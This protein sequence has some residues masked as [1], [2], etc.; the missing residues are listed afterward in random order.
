MIAVNRSRLQ[1]RQPR[2]FILT[3]V[4]ETS[5]RSEAGSYFAV[6]KH[7]GRQIRRSLKTTDRGIAR[8]KLAEF[9]QQLRGSVPAAG[10]AGA[11]LTFDQLAKRWL[12]PVAVHLKS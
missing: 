3:R 2:R 5:Y 7:Q 1:L 10:H 11:T 9:R 6:V 8:R 4:G 12:D